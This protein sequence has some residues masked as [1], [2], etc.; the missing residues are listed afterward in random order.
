MITENLTKASDS[1]D[2]AQSDLTQA[3]RRANPLVALPL[4]D[5]IGRIAEVKQDV[6]SLILAIQATTDHA[7]A[8]DSSLRQACEAALYWL[9]EEAEKPGR[10]KP[11]EILRVLQSALD[12]GENTGEQS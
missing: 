7:E 6:D 10:A 1:L 4:P 8:N 11:D 2:F 9:I 5:L 12:A 3:L